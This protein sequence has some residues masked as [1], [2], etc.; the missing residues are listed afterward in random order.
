VKAKLAGREQELKLIQGGEGLPAGNPFITKGRLYL[1]T[2]R[3]DF[4]HAMV[5]ELKDKGLEGRLLAA[6]ILLANNDFENAGPLI[7]ELIESASHVD[8]VRA[9]AYR[10]W[11]VVDDLKLVDGTQKQRVAE[12]D[13]SQADLLASANLSTMLLDF[14]GA[15]E[16]YEH[17]LSLAATTADSGEAFHGL[18]V[19]FYRKRDFDASFDYLKRAL[20]VSA[21]DPDL[22]MSTSSTLIRLG[23]TADAIEFAKLAVRI[24]P[25]HERAHYLL[26]NGYSSKNYTELYAAYPGAF[27][28]EA[29]MAAIREADAL[30]AEG[31][32]SEARKAY[33]ALRSDHSEW[34]EV[35]SRLGSLDFA[36]R[37]YERARQRFGEALEICPEYGRAHNGMA[38]VLEA[39]RLE[40]EVHR[41]AY[42]EI[43]GATATPEIPGIEECVVNWHALS[44]RH[45]KRVALSVEPC[46]RFIPVLVEAGSTYYIKP[47]YELL[48]ETPGQE[49]LRDQRISYDSRLWDD[50]RG[51]GGY[52]TVTGIEDVERTILNRYNT[53]LH[54]L[55]HQVHAVLP[56]DRKREIQELYR[57]TKEKD[58]AGDDAF[59]SR[60]AGGSVWEY[61]AEGA[62]SLESPR[63]DRYDTREIVRERLDEKDPELRGLVVV[64][65]TEADV[66]SCYAVAYSNRGDDRLGRG[67]PDEAIAAY[68]Q[69]I[70][71]SP[72]EETALSSLVYALKVAGRKDE[73]LALAEEKY[74][75][76]Q[77]SAALALGYA[78]ALWVSGRGL[79][80]A[81]EALEAARPLVRPQEIYRIDLELGRLR[82]IEGNAVKSQEAY[83]AVLDYQADDPNGLWGMASALALAKDWARAWE[84]YEEGVRIRTG[85]V[86]L[87]ADYARDLLRAGEKDRAREQVDA[88]LLLDAEDPR[89]LALDAWILLEEM[90]WDRAKASATRALEFGL[91]SDL[92]RIVLA[93]VEAELFNEDEAASIKAP[94]LKRLREGAP[95]E[96]VYRS[97]W[98]RYDQVHTLPA[99][100]RALLVES[101]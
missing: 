7:Q 41:D 48:S 2:G 62:N 5:A 56:A 14:D 30:L 54:E 77:E 82:W 25:Y 38:K 42:E 51:C 95:P 89:I 49:L 20:V 23:R 59:L 15:A 66:E 75:N 27:A 61:F 35:P 68:E 64:L 32:P 1:E 80:T 63:R 3:H 99:V 96:Y 98:G 72:E 45:Q 17:A 69:A 97:K 33:E 40:V 34:V 26:G 92:A 101:D 16:Q 94:V 50:V 24:S 76:N 18:G 74:R 73:A 28:D 9:L 39:Q 43:F 31:K 47:L 91:W 36:E 19:A 86:E 60:Y 100:E 70:E 10:W 12:G 87:R 90:E 44:P 93:R 67:K 85:V 11:V 88:G 53:V 84:R 65:T 29:G 81:I 55:T 22:L 52:N 8:K 6:K 71:R 46:K 57:K 78:D 83:A 13:A 37:D 4:A 79:D 21:P 58:Q